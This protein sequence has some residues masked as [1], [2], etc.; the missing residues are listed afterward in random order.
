M[1]M[2]PRFLLKS[3]KQSS[4][5]ELQQLNETCVP[6]VT[7]HGTFVLAAVAKHLPYNSYVNF[8]APDT[9]PCHM[10]HVS[11]LCCINQKQSMGIC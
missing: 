9:F 3:F 10:K 7:L 2:C 4:W 6:S 1:N 11:A 5:L 8:V